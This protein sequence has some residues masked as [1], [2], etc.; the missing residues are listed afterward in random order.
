MF[1]GIGELVK[2]SVFVFIGDTSDGSDDVISS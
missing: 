1:L 2:E